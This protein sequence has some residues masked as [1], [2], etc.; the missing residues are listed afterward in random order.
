MGGHRPYPTRHVGH[1]PQIGR[2]SGHRRVR[3]LR[4][5]EAS[6]L[7]RPPVTVTATVAASK[8]SGAGWSCRSHL[9]LD[10]PSEIGS[11]RPDWPTPC[12]HTPGRWR[13]CPAPYRTLRAPGGSGL[14][15]DNDQSSATGARAGRPD[16]LTERHPSAPDEWAYFPRPEGVDGCSSTRQS[17]SM[18]R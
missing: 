4:C 6:R 15:S 10:D 9:R 16:C 18:M 7:C 14:L 8:T 17:A 2:R 3:T 12:F 11:P 1:G 13:L 5:P